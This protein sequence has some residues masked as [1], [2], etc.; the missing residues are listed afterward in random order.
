M[1][2]MKQMNKICKQYISEIKAFFPIMGKD[3]KKYI[4]KLKNNIE[5]YC[6]EAGITTKKELYKNYGFPNNVVNDYYSSLDT[7]YIVKK[8]KFSKHIK[9]LVSV[10][11]ILLIIV[12]S[13]FCAFWYQNHQMYL[14]E[15]AII[16]ESVIE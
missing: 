7:D 13:V 16:T 1:E 14:R 12:T 2:K 5:S 9:A 8:I 15:E 10:I 3:E 6:D 11:L 4:A